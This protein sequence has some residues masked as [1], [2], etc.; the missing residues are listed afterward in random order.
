[1][2]VATNDGKPNHTPSVRLIQP[3][4]PADRRRSI[5]FSSN[6]LTLFSVRLTK[7]SAHYSCRQKTGANFRR[8]IFGISL[9]RRVVL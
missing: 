2:S 9:S 8:K 6:G 1:M 3:L 4:L 5:D 7:F